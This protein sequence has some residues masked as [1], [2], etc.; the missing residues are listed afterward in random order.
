MAYYDALIAEWATLTGT[1][2]QKLAA[3]NALTVAGQ[4]VDVDVSAVVGKLMLSGAY[5]PLLSFSQGPTNSNPTHDAA[6][7]SAKSLMTLIAIPNAPRFQMSD[8]TTFATVKGMMD[9]ILAEETATPGSTGFTQAVHDALLALCAT[10][11]PWWQ[12]ATGGNLSSPV[13]ANDTASAG[14]T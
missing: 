7:A 9:A 4:N 12:A 11:I 6:L 8:P 14:L 2:A 3:V 13:S 5:F 10:V 1:T